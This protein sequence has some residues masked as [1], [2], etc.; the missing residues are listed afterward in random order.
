MGL[1]VYAS[2]GQAMNCSFIHFRVGFTRESGRLPAEKL[3]LNW[4]KQKH[5]ALSSAHSWAFSD[6]FGG[7]GAWQLL[8]A[9]VN[10]FFNQVLF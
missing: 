3:G 9:C 5:A 8:L 10:F 2:S 4:K 7:H 6:G 1:R